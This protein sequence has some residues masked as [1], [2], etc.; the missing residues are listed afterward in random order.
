MD[1]TRHVEAL[2]QQ[3]VIAAEP[4]GEPARELAGRL[5]A[6]DASARLVLLG[7]LSAAAEEITRELAP[8]SVEVRLRGSDPEFVVTL[9]EPEPSGTDP[10][11]VDATVTSAAPPAAAEPDDG[12]TS[13][14]TLRL[15]DQLKVRIE[16]AAGRDGVS[17]NSW[18][19]RAVSDAVG[20]SGRSSPPR[21]RSASGGQRITG[22]AR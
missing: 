20:S 14:I 5:V 9:P 18:L 10:T 15:P 21:R 1:L 19:V 4:G 3:L 16:D 12:G 2:R 11:N 7:A 6:L 17:V 22:W 13:R 8:G